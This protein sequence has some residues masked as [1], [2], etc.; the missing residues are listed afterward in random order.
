MINQFVGI[1]RLVQSHALR[2]TSNNKSV[3]EFT[4]AINNTKEDTTFLKIT[5]FG[6][7]ADTVNEYCRKGD[8]ISVV[9]SVRNHNWEDKNGIKHYDYNFIANKI[10]LLSSNT[11]ILK[12]QENAKNDTKT[13]YKE[14]QD[15]LK[16]V[17]N[18][19]DPFN[20]FNLENKEELNLELPF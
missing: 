17:V 8:M 6:K 7:I 13:A 20:E 3:C 9:C 4:I 1:G 12:E 15:I 11:N 5:T 10:S 2:Y 14:E 19:T 18:E 16:D